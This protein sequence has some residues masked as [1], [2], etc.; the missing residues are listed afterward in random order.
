[1][2]KNFFKRHVSVVTEELI[3]T[4]PAL[5]LAL[6]Q[7]DRDTFIRLATTSYDAALGTMMAQ[8]GDSS[9]WVLYDQMR[10]GL[11]QFLGDLIVSRN[12]PLEQLIPGLDRTDPELQT[13]SN[14]RKVLV[15]AYQL[16]LQ[17]SPLKA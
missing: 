11:S 17:Q 14:A 2:E 8:A 1:M 13:V 15:G 10:N 12:Q 4:N 3:G 5:A 6:R 7:M 9:I 16:R